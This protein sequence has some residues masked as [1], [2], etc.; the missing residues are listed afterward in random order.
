MSLAAAYGCAVTAG[1]ALDCWSGDS[2]P[3]SALAG[4]PT[5]GVSAV[6]VGSY[7]GYAANDFGC[8]LNST[9]GVSCWGDDF[10]GQLG[11]GSTTTSPVP[12]LILGLESG[13]TAI[14]AGN[15]QRPT[16]C[17]VVSGGVKCWG[18][19][20][21]ALGNGTTAVE[22]STPVPITGFGG[23][24][25]TAVSVG[26]DANYAFACA[27]TSAGAVECWGN[28]AEGQLGNGTT[29]TSTVP[30]QVTGLTSGVTAIAAGFESACAIT[31]GGA[32]QCWGNNSEGELGNGTTT[33]VSSPQPVTG[34][35]SGVTSLSSTVNTTCAVTSTGAVECWGQN[36]VGQVGDGTT[37]TRLTPTPV[38]TLTGGATNV[39]VGWGW[40]CAV[41]G[42]GVWCWG[43][44]S[45]VPVH[46]AG[47]AE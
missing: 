41:V 10:W 25:V 45:H 46:V 18:Y 17:A 20:A 4:G 6:A 22:S 1:G 37:T 21:G 40:A 27:I 44:A 34:L 23:A 47:F 9:G 7:Y 30:V 19:N 8:L 43:G 29:T 16:A 26:G 39:A 3:A 12:G 36:N 15:G 33:S 28:N 32:V 11:N 13:V 14:A 5:S 35:T 2:G 24:T 38:T 42:G 31:A